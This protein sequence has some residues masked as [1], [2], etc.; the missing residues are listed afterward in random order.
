MAIGQEKCL[1]ACLSQTSTMDKFPGENSSI[2]QSLAHSP[3]NSLSDIYLDISCQKIPAAV[4]YLFSYASIIVNGMNSVCPRLPA[5]VAC[6]LC[7]IISYVFNTSVLW[8][9]YMITFISVYTNS[10]EWVVTLLD[11]CA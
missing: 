2:G 3:R 10:I 8:V 9:K 11:A 6:S 1:R 4:F 7:S 5:T